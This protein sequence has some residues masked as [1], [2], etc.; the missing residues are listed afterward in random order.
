MV[1]TKPKGNTAVRKF[2]RNKLDAMMKLSDDDLWAEIVRVG[3]SKG[4]NLPSGTPPHAELERLRR[5]VS[6]GRINIASALKIID[7][8]RKSGGGGR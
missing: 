8:Y 5:T 4:F 1:T 3:A 7:A 2:D 6:D